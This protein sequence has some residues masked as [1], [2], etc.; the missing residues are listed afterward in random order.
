MPTFKEAAFYVEN[1]VTYYFKDTKARE[2]LKECFSPS[3]PPPAPSG[4]L[5][6]G[7]TTGQVP[8]KRS[9]A[10]YDVEWEDESGG[11]G[12]PTNTWYATCGTASGT[13]AKTATSATGDFVLAT[14]AMV[15]VLFS[16]SNTAANPTISIDGS[17]A[18]NIRPVSGASG[19]D[20]MW[21]AGEV[22]DLVYD[23]SNFVMTKGGKADTS[24]YGIT[25]LDSSTNSTATDVAATPK[26]VKDVKDMIPA[27]SSATP[28]DLGTAAAGSSA[29]YSRAD[30]VHNKPT[31]TK[32]DVGLGN[33][34]NVQQYS[35]SNPPPYP[36]TSVNGQTGA[37]KV[38]TIAVQ[39]SA[40]VGG[41]L[42]WIDTDEP[43]D[44]VTIPQIDDDNVSEDDTWSSQKIRDFIY[45]IGSIY[46]SVNATSPATIFGGTW[47]Q[48]EDTFLLA[49]GTNYAAGSTGGEATHTLTGGELPKTSG[50]W[51]MRRMSW[52]TGS[53]Q[54]SAIF[55]GTSGIASSDTGSGGADSVAYYSG[56][57]RTPDRIKLAF[58]NDEAHNNMPPYLAVY[59][60]KR[61]A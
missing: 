58:G 19:M 6:P 30:H 16:N 25:K 14:G 4:V 52:G 38:S 51:W 7:G 8:K 61:T 37:V 29:D 48:I 43:G 49:A 54:S 31:Y 2:Q 24:F 28:Q 56:V 39:D 9:N 13:G 45:P 23:G 41:E 33:V 53:T 55:G 20:Y 59:V 47:E 10:D 50:E 15:R 1:G 17:T 18:K 5:P 3:N 44:N 11:G 27:A 36:V 26:A 12:G 46:M 40:P 60:W 32:G 34:D 35:A 21:K 42:V 57:S 22:I